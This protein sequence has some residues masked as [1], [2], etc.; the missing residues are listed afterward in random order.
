[1]RADLLVVAGLLALGALLLGCTGADGPGVHCPDDRF[2]CVGGQELARQPPYCTYPACL[3]GQ[4]PCDYTSGNITW[5]SRSAGECAR[6]LDV[7]CGPNDVAFNNSCGC[8]CRLAF[9]RS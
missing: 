9:V 4:M 5:L 2:V 6:L 3:P 8:G 1:M 7:V